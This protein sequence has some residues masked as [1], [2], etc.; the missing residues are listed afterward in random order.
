MI[1]VGTV[2]GSCRW[3]RSADN[4]RLTDLARHVRGCVVGFVWGLTVAD[5]VDVVQQLR[6]RLKETTVREEVILDPR[7]RQRALVRRVG[8]LV[9]GLGELFRGR[10]GGEEPTHAVLPSRPGPRRLDLDAVVA[11]QTAAVSLD[12]A[13]RLGWGGALARRDDGDEVLPAVGEELVAAGLVEPVHLR[14][15]ATTAVGV[16]TQ[17]SKKKCASRHEHRQRKIPRMMSSVT[18]EGWVSA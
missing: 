3:R 18:R 5:L 12:E 11:D 9:E 6:L 14:L 7:Q 17:P 2:R 13:D 4:N 15:P 1:V 8:G 16:K 10:V